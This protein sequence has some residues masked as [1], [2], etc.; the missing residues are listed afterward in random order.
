MSEATRADL[1]NYYARQIGAKSYLEI[2]VQTGATFRA[3]EIDHKVGVDPDP[4]SKATI[5]TTSDQFF[6]LNNERFDIVFVDGLHHW[7]TALRDIH[8][9]AAILNEGGVIIVDDIAPR[10]QAHQTRHIS[11]IHWTGDVWKAWFAAVAEYR[12]RFNMFSLDIAFGLGV[13]VA[14]TTEI[15]PPLLSAE[16][17][18]WS[19]YVAHRAR[20]HKMIKF[21]ELISWQREDSFSYPNG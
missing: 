17:A 1:I 16:R 7:E 11:D 14:G 2:G 15:D 3:V 13:M 9:A 4:L 18:G 21:E 12:G 20:Y 8:N 5:H 10:K 19:D 6:S